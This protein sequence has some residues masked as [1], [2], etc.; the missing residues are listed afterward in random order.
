MTIIKYGLKH[1]KYGLLGFYTG[2]NSGDDFCVDV[3]YE[4]DHSCEPLWLVDNYQTALDVSTQEG[5]WYNADYNSPWNSYTNE[6]LE[7]VKIELKFEV[8]K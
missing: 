1:P 3:G 6:S 7:V 2:S 4:L 8:M 5:D